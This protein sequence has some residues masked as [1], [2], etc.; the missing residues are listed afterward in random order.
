MVLNQTAERNRAS[1]ALSAELA[2]AGVFLLAVSVYILSG[3]GRIDMID[4]QLRYEVTASLIDDGRPIIRDPALKFV[5]VRGPNGL[6]YAHYNAGGSIVGLFPVWLGSLFPDPDG[7]LRRFLF[8]L[9]SCFLGA[10]AAALLYLF[11]LDLG[12]SRKRALAWT[13][14]SSFA[15]LLW[16]ASTSS[17]D[18]AQHAFFLLLAVYLGHRSATAGPARL[19]AWAGL[20]AGVPILYQ[21]YLAIL[22]PALA[23]STL[24]W[25]AGP[26]G[27][28]N[29]ELS[30]NVVEAHGQRGSKTE[31]SVG[32]MLLNAPNFLK[33]LDRHSQTRYALFIV[34]AGLGLAL[35]LVYNW[36]RFGSPFALG[37]ALLERQFHFPLFG[38]PLVG[39][40]TLLLSPGKSIFLY[41]PPIILG[42]LGFR[43]LRRHV[44]SLGLTLLAASVILVLF[45][46]NIAFVGGDWCWG[47]RYLVPLLPLWALAFP[48]VT[49]QRFRRSLVAAIVGAGLA[50]QLAALAVDHQ[51]FFFERG[52]PDYFWGED[53]WFYFK[54]SALVA[55]PGEIASLRK[56]APETAKQFAPGPYP[57]LQ[58]YCIFGNPPS[59]RSSAPVW[60]RQFSVFYLP[61]PWPF[62]M[63]SFEQERRPINT[64]TWLRGSLTLAM[65]GIVC[66][67][68]GLRSPERG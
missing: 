39:L 55:R 66:I 58:T 67:Y 45:L 13:L 28:P 40:A 64:A 43:R 22:A 34:G 23:L 44:P 2:A 16:P 31:R 51:R 19:A 35:A 65:A 12:I 48:F 7:E 37:S 50:V 42:L 54:H 63:R 53:P 27:A 52:L 46:S 59:K 49:V 1:Q 33:S 36:F 20:A 68:F 5:G 15:T 14:V 57:F 17:F 18:N 60:M 61:R 56:G 21:E 41:S 6:R 24:A 11:Y 10:A 38:N 9:T 29:Q 47:P 32:K 8:S 3:P 30:P 26:S 62:W 4:G 25:P